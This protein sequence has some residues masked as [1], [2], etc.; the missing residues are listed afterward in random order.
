MEP[1]VEKSSWVFLIIKYTLMVI[2]AA[3]YIFAG[4]MHFKKP[5]YYEAMM[6]AIL[7]FHKELN[8]ISGA[9]EILGGIGLLV[10]WTRKFSAW[11]LIALLFAVLPANFHIALFNVPVF[12]AT[13]PPGW[14]AWLR[15]PV[16]ALLIMWARWYTK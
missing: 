9:F 8:L 1:Y 5:E 16:Q 2:M 7:P 4:Y 10:P 12:G 6:P 13:E 3:I 11:G 14:K 15:I